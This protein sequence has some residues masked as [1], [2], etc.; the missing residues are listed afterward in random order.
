MALFCLLNTTEFEQGIAAGFH[1]GH[2]GAEI[3]RDLQIQMRGEFI[4]EFTVLRLLAKQAVKADPRCS[5]RPHVL[6]SSDSRKRARMAVVCCH[7]RVSFSS[8]RRPARVN[9]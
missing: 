6:P 5:K 7:S 4:V 1:G 2:A 9:L 8:C 3:V